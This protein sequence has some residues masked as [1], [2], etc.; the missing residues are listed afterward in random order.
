[1]LCFNFL[2]PDSPTLP[3]SQHSSPSLGACQTSVA[4]MIRSSTNMESSDNGHT[5]ENNYT[6][7]VLQSQ[8][9]VQS[10]ASSSSSE[11]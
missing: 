1:I 10:T 6:S 4:N 2:Q 5:N 3:I 7:N 9:S 11:K 8:V